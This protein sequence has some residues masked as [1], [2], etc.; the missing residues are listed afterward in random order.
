[1]YRARLQETQQ[2]GD[3]GWIAEQKLQQPHS[4]GEREVGILH[5]DAE[6]EVNTLEFLKPQ[7]GYTLAVKD[8]PRSDSKT[9]IDQP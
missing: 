3:E 5:Q 4:A 7:K 8:I 1:M 9:K 2:P 6:T